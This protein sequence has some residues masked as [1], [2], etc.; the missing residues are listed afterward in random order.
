MYCTNKRGH[1]TITTMSDISSVVEKEF[2]WINWFRI[3]WHLFFSWIFSVFN[4]QRRRGGKFVFRVRP[5]SGIKD[6]RGFSVKNI[7]G[8]FPTLF[9]IQKPIA[10]ED[11]IPVS[12]TDAICANREIVLFLSSYTIFSQQCYLFVSTQIAAEKVFFLRGVE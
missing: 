6:V 8:V 1:A 2:Y 4:G 3:F 10:G 7:D 9:S 12:Y 5:S 11:L